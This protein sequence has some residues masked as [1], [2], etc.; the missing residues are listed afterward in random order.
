MD[1]KEAKRAIPHFFADEL[2]GRQLKEFVWHL[3]KCQDCMEETT[4]Q[5]LATEGI[6]RLEEGKTFELDKELK[7]KLESAMRRERFR[8]RFRYTLVG[9]E[10]LSLLI[11]LCVF[12]YVFL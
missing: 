9:I 5:Y 1:C 4:I 10:I 7:E 12:I 8:K 3:N 2:E 11:I 6:L